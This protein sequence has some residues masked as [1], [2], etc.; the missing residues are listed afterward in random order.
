MSDNRA[1]PPGE[2]AGV[3]VCDWLRLPIQTCPAREWRPIHPPLLEANLRHLAELRR[4]AEAETGVVFE[5]VVVANNDPSR[6]A[7][8]VVRSA[9]N[10]ATFH[11]VIRQLVDRPSRLQLPLVERSDHV[12]PELQRSKLPL[13]I[14]RQPIPAAHPLCEPKCFKFPKPAAR[15]CSPGVAASD[16]ILHETVSLGA[17][18]QPAVKARKAIRLSLAPDTPLRVRARQVSKP[19]LGDLLGPHPEAV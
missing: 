14:R 11:G 2:D 3:P 16:S 12:A 15:E 18:K 8:L 4:R 19:F 10:D 7:Q 17:L 9:R 6:P 13:Q 1:L 5:P